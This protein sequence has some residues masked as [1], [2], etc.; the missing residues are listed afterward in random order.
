[1]AINARSSLLVGGHYRVGRKLQER[2]MGRVHAAVDR[3]D[4]SRVAIKIATYDSNDDADQDV[5]R[6]QRE[7]VALWHLRHPSIVRMLDAGFCDEGYY[8]A[9]EYLDGFSVEEML[10]REKPMPY[11]AAAQV[12]L[13]VLEALIVTHQAGLIHRDVKAGN[14]MMSSNGVKL[15]DFGLTTLTARRRPRRITHPQMT[16]G[17]A[18]YMAP[19]QCRGTDGLDA[20][21]DVYA[22][23]HLL[24]EMLTGCLAIPDKEPSRILSR[25]INVLPT[26]FAEVA[27]A[28]RVPAALQAVAL[29]ALEKQPR[30]R[31][32]TAEEMHQAI[33]DAVP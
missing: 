17:T 18:A 19:E 29:R 30:H 9:L 20:R 25:Q 6:L 3:R 2:G 22:C 28:A 12:T 1:M 16:V 33:L 11:D 27:P 21:V 24:Y 15:I 8:L 4:G 7:A 26:P 5:I 31:F 32:Q 13:R 10:M 23:G 14:V